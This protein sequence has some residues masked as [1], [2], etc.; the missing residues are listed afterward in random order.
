[1]IRPSAHPGLVYLSLPP[2]LYRWRCEP[3]GVRPIAGAAGA[4]GC[5]GYYHYFMGYYQYHY[6]II[7]NHYNITIISI[8]YKYYSAMHVLYCILYYGVSYAITMLDDICN[9]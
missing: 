7:I 6:H 5:L 2:G 8:Y 9:T 4:R 1:M 3:G